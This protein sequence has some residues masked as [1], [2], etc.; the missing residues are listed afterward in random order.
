MFV[1]TISDIMAAVALIIMIIVAAFVFIIGLPL[2][3]GERAQIKRIDKFYKRG[4]K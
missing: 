3:F 4:R 2:V 1:Y